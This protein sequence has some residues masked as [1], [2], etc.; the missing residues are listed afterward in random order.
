[1]GLRLG[2][3]TIDIPAGERD[4]VIR[5]SYVL[6]VDV[7]LFAVQPHAHYL[8]RRMDATATL[9]DGTIQ[10]LISIGDWDFRWQ[11]VYRYVRAPVLPK[12][13]VISMRFSYDNSSENPRN[14]TRPPRRATWGPNTNEEMGD[15]W[16]QVVPRTR[17]DLPLLRSDVAQKMRRDDLAAAGKLLRDDP[18]NPLRH[19][20][21]AL[22]QLQGGQFDDA[23]RHY[24]ESL[25]LDPASAP[26]HYNLAE[27]FLARGRLDEA[28]AE[29]LEAVRL[30]PD[31]AEAHNNAGAVLLSAGR[32]V[33]ALQQFRRALE[34]N[35]ED[36]DVQ[37]NLARALLAGANH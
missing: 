12:G 29:F 20:G 3:E 18:S 36:A 1:M 16:L 23:I 34:L 25:N 13:T 4:Y 9:P 24:H 10:P 35:P 19:D 28:L 31:Y 30:D 27:A 21:V 6:P 22:L 8:G 11:D 33:E 5:D 37:N 32:Q 7:D 15:L 14:P 26:T 2:S 17:S